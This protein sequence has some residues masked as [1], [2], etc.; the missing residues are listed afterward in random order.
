MDKGAWWATVHGVAKSR[1]LKWLST[2]LPLQGLNQALLQLLTFNTPWREFRVESRNEA[3]CALGKTGR[4]GFQID[5]FRCW[6][7]EPN[8]CIS[9][10][11]EKHQIPSWNSS[12]KVNF[13]PTTN[14]RLSSCVFS[15]NSS[16]L[17]SDLSLYSPTWILTFLVHSYLWPF[18]PEFWYSSQLHPNS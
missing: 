5:I 7:Y 11:L 16:F 18:S 15:V 3:L 4:T 17:I 14:C 9:S 1:T 8:S 10:Y 12:L 6:S 2:H 13:W